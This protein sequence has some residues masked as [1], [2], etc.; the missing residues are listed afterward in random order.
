MKLLIQKVKVVDRN[1]PYNGQTVDIFIENGKITE[2]G[3]SID[4]EDVEVWNNKN[5]CVSMG[6]VDVGSYTNDPGEEFKEDLYSISQAAAFG[7][8][9]TVLSAANTHPTIDSKSKV[10]YI[11]NSTRHDLVDFHPLGAV[12]KGCEG[13]EIAEMFDMSHH[14]ALGFS[15]GFHSIQH[16]GIMMRALMYVK[17]FDG[18]IFNEPLDTHISSKGYVHEGIQ[19]TTV[20]MSGIPALAESMMVQR[21]L[22]LLEYTESKLHLSNISTAESVELIRQAKAKGLDVTASVNPMNL[23]FTD[24]VI[25]NFDTNYKVKPPI[26]SEEHRSA[27]IDGLKDGT[28]DFVNTNHRAQDTESKRLEFM[29]ADDGVIM[30]ETA[31]AITNMV[32]T[33]VLDLETLISKFTTQQRTIFNLKNQKIDIGEIADLTIFNPNEEW[34]YHETEILSNSKN[35]PFKNEYL[36]GRVIGV[37]N[38]NQSKKI[39]S[40]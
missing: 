30:L 34:A 12:T 17:A 2:I 35:T 7:G 1:S 10:L 25:Q 6:W 24:K 21:D 36:K 28:I 22:Y 31:F 9:T 3:T 33:D 27:L 15:D 18:R 13:K 23:F 8:F 4:K 39:T 20:G 5:A 32:T 40:L 16:S 29:Y 26:R 38:N 11:I 37:V 14:G 19:S